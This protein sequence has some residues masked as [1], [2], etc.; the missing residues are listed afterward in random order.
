MNPAATTEESL[1]AL[2]SW[3]EPF[4]SVLVA[5]SGGVDSALVLAVAQESTRGPR[6][7]RRV[8]ACLG[9]SPSL[10]AR[11]RR[12]AVQLA[13]RLGVECR[14][15]ATGEAEDPRYAANPANRCYFCKAH[16]HDR[17][18]EIAAA[19]GYDVAVD[20]NHADDLVDHRHGMAAGRQ[21]GVRSPLAEVGIGKAEVRQIARGLGLPVWD[22]PATACLSSRV[23][24]G[25]PVTP[26][27]LRRIESAE[28][29]LAALGF[30]QFRVRHHGEVARIE[31]PPEDFGRAVEVAAV[32][33]D[34]IRSC[35][36]RF[37]SLDL[38]GF[39]SGSLA[40]VELTVS[41]APAGGAAVGGAAGSAARQ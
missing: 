10:P 34:R 8:L 18:R 20:G 28:D 39:R 27:L 14:Q 25:T 36:Y 22:K 5:F 41:R 33:V 21:R 11:E 9:V 23:P 26:H 29:V 1:A 2:R 12:A 13:E 4:Q 35:G 24:H 19:E 37:V 38:G 3:F 17:L 32:L 6:P 16:L 40:T 7:G 31:V 30:A 15:V